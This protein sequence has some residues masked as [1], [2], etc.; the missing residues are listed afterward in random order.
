M[1]EYYID[2]AIA[3]SVCSLCCLLSDIQGSLAGSLQA[4][5]AV[6]ALLFL[7]AE[8]P[9]LSDF[10]IVVLEPEEILAVAPV[11]G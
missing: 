6:V 4:E 9:L 7:H 8:L 3:Q 11:R 2:Y 10:H 5:P 1:E